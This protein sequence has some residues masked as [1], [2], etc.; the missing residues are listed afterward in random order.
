MIHAAIAVA[1]DELEV[2]GLSGPALVI[3]AIVLI[4]GVLLLIHS[5]PKR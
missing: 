5:L 4:I 3:A 1:V 2:A